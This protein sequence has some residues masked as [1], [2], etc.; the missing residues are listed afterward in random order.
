MDNRLQDAIQLRQIY[1]GDC[2]FPEWVINS[3]LWNY[4]QFDKTVTFYHKQDSLEDVKRLTLEREPCNIGMRR[5]Y[6]GDELQKG[7][8]WKYG[9]YGLSTPETPM[10]NIAIYC[11]ATV[12]TEK[13]GFFN[14]HVLNLIGCALDSPRQPDFQI[15][16]TTESIIEFYRNMWNLALEAVKYLGKTKF[17]IYNVGGGAFAGKYG[18]E[19]TA[20][21][22]EPAF[23]PLLPEFQNAGI[24]ILGYDFNTHEFTGGFIPD[25]L[26]E[27]TQDLDNTIY[28]N[29][30]DPFSLIG[31]GNECDNSLDGWWGRCSNMA[32][33]GWL[34]TNPDMKF[35]GV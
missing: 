23:L 16:K 20:T 9:A 22:F 31:N 13:K 25:C 10:P 5:L 33:L 26:N 29:A 3:K 27:P 6:D 12:H 28:V 11:N 8:G 24:T 18:D 17:Q 14:T 32:I 4:H 35:V 34:K 30:W 21:I 15:Y 1:W 2:G 19:F 7:F